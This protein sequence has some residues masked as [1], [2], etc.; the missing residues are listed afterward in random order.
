MRKANVVLIAMI[1]LLAV[2][3]ASTGTAFNAPEWFAEL[4]P[5]DAI[6]GIGIARLENESLAMQTATARARQDAAAQIAARVEALLT[7]YANEAGLADN[8]R[9]VIAIENIQ[10]TLVNMNLSG[11]TPNARTR[12]DDGAWF[13][14]VAVR[15]ADAQRTIN[16]AVNNEMANYAEFR[17]DRAI[18]MLN[19]EISKTQFKSDGRSTD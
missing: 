19:S 2:G 12:M 17:A 11:A 8:P 5:E 15:K 10:R 16:S 6:W 18:Q 7:D 9:S 4:P 14:R 1:A 13:V 3:C